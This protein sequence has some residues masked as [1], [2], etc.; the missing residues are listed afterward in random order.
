MGQQ[1]RYGRQAVDGY[2]VPT[3]QR[4]QQIEEAVDSIHD[5]VRQT[6]YGGIYSGDGT[7][8]APV[9]DKLLAPM[10]EGPDRVRRGERVDG[11]DTIL[12]APPPSPG[13]ACRTGC[14]DPATT[15]LP[16]CSPA[17]ASPKSS[18]PASAP[19]TSN[20]SRS[21]EEGRAMCAAS[22]AGLTAWR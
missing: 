16:A 21:H 19:A 20:P 18:T 11:A 1:R 13:K 8:R 10:L 12:V 5:H 6:A 22:E 4:R 3:G 17:T 2:E 15:H 14:T 7:W 9:D